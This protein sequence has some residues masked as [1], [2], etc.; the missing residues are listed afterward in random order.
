MAIVRVREISPQRQHVVDVFAKTRDYT[1]AFTVLSDTADES[2]PAIRTA[3]AGGQSIPLFW[4][5]HPD[6]PFVV[7]FRKAVQQALNSEFARK[8]WLV[9]CNYAIKPKNNFEE[10]P[11]DRPWEIEYNGETFQTIAEFDKFSIGALNSAGQYFDPPLQVDNTRGVLRITRNEP[12]PNTVAANNYQE[13][14]N[15]D[16]FLGG[17]PY[18]V[19]LKRVTYKRVI[20]QWVPP[21]AEDPIDVEYWPHSYEF[22]YW[23]KTWWLFPLDQGR[24]ELG[25]GEGDLV[26]IKD[27]EGVPVVDPVPLD[28]A[29]HQVPPAS[30]PGAAVFLTKRYYPELPFAALGFI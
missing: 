10:H 3:S 14:I 5:V 18:T 19:K 20:E 22:H 24:Y 15:S 26:S 21:L 29:G 25:S 8:F 13:A 4:S 6:D 1:R 16:V 28:G 12:W 7:C 11:L 2:L 30:L 17:A 23:W 27:S 9:T